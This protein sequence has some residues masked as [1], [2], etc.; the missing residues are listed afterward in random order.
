MNHP[1][2]PNKIL[3]FV[4]NKISVLFIVNLSIIVHLSIVLIDDNQN[5]LISLRCNVH[6]RDFAWQKYLDKHIICCLTNHD[7]K[8]YPFLPESHGVASMKK[9]KVYMVFLKILLSMEVFPQHKY[10]LCPLDLIILSKN[11]QQNLY[12]MV[13][14]SITDIFLVKLFLS[15][16]MGCSGKSVSGSLISVK[17]EFLDVFTTFLPSSFETRKIV[18]L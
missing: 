12:L 3:T 5:S 9:R 15:S 11:M 8:I 13:S 18:I 14:S 6:S 2:L 10:R 1:E 7:I 16:C 17:T 4:K